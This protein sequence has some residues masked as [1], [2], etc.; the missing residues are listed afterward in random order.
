[1]AQSQ[2]TFAV[3]IARVVAAGA[4]NASTSVDAM[5]LARHD[6]SRSDEGV[7]GRQTETH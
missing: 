7:A 3:V 2:Y 4:P 1:M 6:E 5:N